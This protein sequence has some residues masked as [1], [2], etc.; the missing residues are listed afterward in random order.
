MEPNRTVVVGRSRERLQ[1]R[2][3]CPYAC[4]VVFAREQDEIPPLA[5][6]EPNVVIGEQATKARSSRKQVPLEVEDRGVVHLARL[7]KEPDS[8]YRPGLDEGAQVGH[9]QPMR[10]VG[11]CPDSATGARPHPAS[12][13]RAERG[14]RD[15]ILARVSRV[16]ELA[17]RSSLSR[18]KTDN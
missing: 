14:N 6:C 17:P 8:E 5:A 3:V 16:R 13:G 18:M 2:R 9:D 10:V 1:M 15:K 11:G 12:K 4:G 7:A